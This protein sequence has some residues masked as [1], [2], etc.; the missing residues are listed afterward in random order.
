MLRKVRVEARAV[1]EAQVRSQ[2][3]AIGTLRDHLDALSQVQHGLE[4]LRVDAHQRREQQPRQLHAVGIAHISRIDLLDIPRQ[5][6]GQRPI[7]VGQAGL[8]PAREQRQAQPDQERETYTALP[9]W[10]AQF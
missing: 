2:R 5:E 4:R 9:R 8:T 10:W 7:G 6:H 1:A 3:H